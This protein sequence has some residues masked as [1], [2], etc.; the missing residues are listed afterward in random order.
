MHLS[1]RRW[2]AFALPHSLA[3]TMAL[4]CITQDTRR[5]QPGTR[6]LL[7]SKVCLVDCLEMKTSV[8]ICEAL[9]G[10]SILPR[11]LS[12]NVAEVWRIT[13]LKYLFL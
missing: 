5:V 10:G 13:E 7:S 11:L 9:Y 6:S 12:N 8:F 2:H 3:E 1:G 4:P